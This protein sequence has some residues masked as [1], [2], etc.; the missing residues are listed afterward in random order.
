MQS[1]TKYLTKRVERLV[2]AVGAGLSQSTTVQATILRDE[3]EIRDLEKKIAAS[4]KIPDPDH[5]DWTLFLSLTQA[6]AQSTHARQAFLARYIQ[7][8]T[9]R[10]YKNHPLIIDE[11][12]PNSIAMAKHK[13]LKDG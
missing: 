10:K 4:R 5:L 11:V 8:V 12:R 1:R 9:L 13:I 3:A 2:G 6:S 7:Q